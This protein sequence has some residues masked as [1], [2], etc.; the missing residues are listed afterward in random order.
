MP[1][2]KR[3]A[4]SNDK[5]GFY[6]H[7]NV[8]GDTPITL[9]VTALAER[10]FDIAGYERGATVPT[11]LVWSMYDLDLLY[12][13]GGTDP[14]AGIDYPDPTTVLEKLG[15]ASKLTEQERADLLFYLDSYSGPDEDRIKELRD[16]LASDTSEEVT[17][18]VTA[19][20]PHLSRDLP[21]TADEIKSILVEWTAAE[22]EDRVKKALLLEKEFVTWSVRT[23]LGHQNFAETPLRDISHKEITYELSHGVRCSEVTITDA[24]GHSDKV[25]GRIVKNAVYDYRIERSLKD[26]THETGYVLGDDV[27]KYKSTGGDSGSA[28]TLGY[29]LDGTLPPNRS[30]FGGT[31]DRD[32]TATQLKTHILDRPSDQLQNDSGGQ[33]AP[34]TETDG[35]DDEEHDHVSS[36]SHFDVL[37]IDGVSNAG[38]AK[39]YVNGKL[40]VITADVRAEVGNRV[41]VRHPAPGDGFQDNMN[42][43]AAVP[44]SELPATKTEEWL[45]REL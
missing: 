2:F 29:D 24:R 3:Y 45:H 8:G 32:H 39:S 7:A 35:Q 11:E 9:Q 1:S 26:G 18:Q 43:T 23:F 4:T 37:T 21:Q 34:T 20:E 36:L 22:M 10:I 13:I 33:A 28:L 44:L 42:I 16:Q 5:D 19:S 14:G 15:V 27:I 6:I 40:V 41:V 12:T 38:N 17:E 25:S 30:H 31:T